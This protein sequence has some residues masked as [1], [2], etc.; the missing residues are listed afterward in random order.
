M[1]EP[2]AA[3]VPASARYVPAVENITLAIT[4]VPGAGM[5]TKWLNPVVSLGV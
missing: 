1:T 5:T 2:S 4:V 3:H